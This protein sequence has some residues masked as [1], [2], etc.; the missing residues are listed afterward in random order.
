MA[1][2]P[3]IDRQA[4]VVVRRGA[5]LLDAKLPGWWDQLEL[6]AF[7]ISASSSCVIGQL[8]RY[9][10]EAFYHAAQREVGSGDYDWGLTVLSGKAVP[11]YPH[12]TSSDSP[13]RREYDAA[14]LARH[15]WAEAYGF[16]DS[17]DVRYAA[18]Q[19]A[20]IAEIARRRHTTR[21]SL[22]AHGAYASLED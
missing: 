18:L 21:R 3:A 4:R 14:L 17:D 19:E 22:A 1:K 10:M 2:L 8:A 11:A 15:E 12:G 6:E 7:N 13:V 16:Q 20:W 5:A 9:D